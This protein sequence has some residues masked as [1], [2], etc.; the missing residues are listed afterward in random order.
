M[1]P[2]LSGPKLVKKSQFENKNTGV[3]VVFKTMRELK[4][5]KKAIFLETPD[6]FF[7]LEFLT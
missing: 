1:N 2:Q 3:S 6:F 4:C 7:Y 5:Q